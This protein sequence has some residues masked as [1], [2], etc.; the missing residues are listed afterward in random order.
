[1]Q[2]I[3]EQLAGMNFV[4]AHLH[5]PRL[6]L[7]GRVSAGER[8]HPT[9]QRPQC[10]ALERRANRPIRAGEDQS[11]YPARRSWEGKRRVD[12][13]GLCAGQKRSLCARVSRC[14]HRDLRSGLSLAAALSAT[15]LPRVFTYAIRTAC[16]GESLAC[17]TSPSSKPC[18]TSSAKSTSW[19]IWPTS[20]TRSPA[21]SRSLQVLPMIWSSHRTG[22]RSG[23]LA[24]MYRITR[25]HR[26]CQ[27]E[28]S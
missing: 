7:G 6:Q 19:T 10:L 4:K 16:T 17:F 20:A 22:D 13:A 15:S 11:S 8:D 26:I 21:S 14:G 2:H 27:V 28:T 25:P 18:A 3:I 5:Q 23:I 24:E 12:R 9:N 1:M